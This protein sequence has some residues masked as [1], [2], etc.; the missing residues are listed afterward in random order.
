MRTFSSALAD[1][2]GAYVKLQR[3]LG[4]QFEHQAVHLH[5][6]DEYLVQRG[7]TE[8]V[9]QEIVIAFATDGPSSSMDRRARRYHVIR[10]FCEYLATYDPQAPVLDPHAVPRS[11]ARPAR[12]I[13]TD[14]ELAQLLQK[15]RN[16]SQHYPVRGVTLHAMI[17][18]AASTG[19]RRGEVVRLDNADVDLESGVLLIRKTKFKKDR[20]VPVHPGTLDVMRTYGAL[21]D[22]AY[23]GRRDPAFFVTMCR[24]RFNSN[25]LQQQFCMAARRAGLRGPTGRGLTFH[26]LRHRFAVKRLAAWY[27]AGIDVQAMLPTLATYMGH[28]HYSDTAYYLTATAELLG[29]AAERYNRRFDK[30]E[31]QP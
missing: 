26:D 22:C 2:L 28:V 6:F 21:R 5:A 16:I 8:P 4:Y 31:A 15:A 14:E 12:H 1:R 9:T 10:R 11:N 30:A 3:A 7:H 23:P 20:L 13:L 29:L 25:T 27:S 18:L 19:L 24:K 17:G